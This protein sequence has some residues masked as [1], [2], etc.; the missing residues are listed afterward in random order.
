MI[1][2]LILFRVLLSWAFEKTI[3]INSLSINNN[4]NNN[5]DDDDDNDSNNKT[6]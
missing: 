5:N 1:R 4:N 3:A 6:T 2:F